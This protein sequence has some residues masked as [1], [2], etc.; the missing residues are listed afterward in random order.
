AFA[1]DPIMRWI[2][3]LTGATK[4]QE[5]FNKHKQDTANIT[6][7]EVAET[8]LLTNKIKDHNIPLAERERLLNEFISRSPAIL[9]ALNLQ[10]IATAE[11]TAILDDYIKS[12]KQR[13]ELQQLE[14]SY[15]ESA[16]RAADLRS[17]ALK[18][19]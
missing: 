18:D 12:L 1:I 13:L 17:G 14:K 16:Q 5:A 10:N 11:G 19:E 7:K 9:K 15:A 8:T 4:A 6:A 2:K 3:A